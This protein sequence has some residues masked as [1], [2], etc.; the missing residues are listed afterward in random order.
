[1]VTPKAASKTPPVGKD[2]D[3]MCTKCKMVLNHV[4]VAKVGDVVKRVKCLTCGS[5]HN[6]KAEA[7]GGVAVKKKK[8]T[9]KKAAGT[10][11]RASD[12]D[13]LMSGRDL[14]RAKRYKPDGAFSKNDVLDHP[15]F[16]MG[17]VLADKEGSKIEVAFQEGPK[18]LVHNLAD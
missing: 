5:E 16:G 6:H 12:W 4:I 14:S 8:A 3:S 1:M 2:I 10:K 11:V 15:K 7:S 9:T 13:T 18:V 17:L